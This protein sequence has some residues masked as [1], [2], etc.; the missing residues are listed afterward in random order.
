MDADPV[1]LG[2][3]RSTEFFI[4]GTHIKHREFVKDRT[5]FFIERVLCKLDFSHVKVTY[6][7]DFEVFVDDL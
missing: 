3:N 6:P 1:Y 5:Q 7:A 2:Q 4:Y